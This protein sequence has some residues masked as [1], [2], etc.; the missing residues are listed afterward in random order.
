MSGKDRLEEYLSLL[1]NPPVGGPPTGGS[2][3]F[4]E[5]AS[6]V[7][8]GLPRLLADPGLALGFIPFKV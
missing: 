5:P 6:W 3:D 2:I 7:P 1:F 8:R 4:V